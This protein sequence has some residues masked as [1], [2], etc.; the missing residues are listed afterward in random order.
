M[1]AALL[2]VLGLVA[3]AACSGLEVGLYAT[4]RLRVALDAAAGVPAALVVQR[5]LAELPRM[6][7]VL[8]VAN[9]LAQ[10]LVSLQTQVLL[11]RWGWER[12]GLVGTVLV[13]AVLFVFSE[14]VPKSAFHRW[15]HE[16]LYPVAPSLVALR[17]LLG[18]AVLPLA[19][20]AELLAAWLSRRGRGVAGRASER[21]ALLSQGA[22][23]GLMSPFQQRVARGVLALRGR[24][25]ATEARPL[26]ELPT[27]RLGQPGVRLPP[28]TRE[29]RVLVLDET[30]ERV[31]GWSP[32][33]ALWTP[34]GFRPAARRDLR[35]VARVEASAGLDRVYAALDRSDAPFAALTVD[36]RAAVID[37]DRLRLRVMGMFSDGG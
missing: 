31:A 13:T 1:S 16:L 28:G 25:A 10:W 17:L 22:A 9:N 29:H 36:G 3:A 30:G 4:S 15:K 7:T 6:L 21:E 23:E 26:T 32:L 20:A 37:V 5:S 11:D 8:L 35:P 34:A 24:E 14:S 12:S 19:R 18:W 2:L 33:A 27:A